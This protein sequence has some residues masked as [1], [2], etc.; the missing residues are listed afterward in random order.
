M[1][2]A[3]TNVFKHILCQLMFKNSKYSLGF[4]CVCPC[5]SNIDFDNNYDDMNMLID[6][7]VV[8]VVVDDD[9]DNDENS[10]P[11]LNHHHPHHQGE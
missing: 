11:L 5:E 1:A 7:D 8:V 4:G 9:D 10:P 2:S 6:E 3:K